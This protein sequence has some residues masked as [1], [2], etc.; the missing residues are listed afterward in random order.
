V[1]RIKTLD[2]LRGLAALS[3]CIFHFTNSNS[4][5]LSDGILKKSGSYGFLGVAVFFVISGY[6]LCNSLLKSKYEIKKFPI[7]ISKRLIRLE[8]PYLLSLVLVIIL[9]YL[10]ERTNI[11]QGQR[12]NFDFVRILSHLGYFTEILGYKWFNPVYWTLAIELQFYILLGIIFPFFYSKTYKFFIVILILL[13]INYLL[14]TD[15]LV[16]HY[17]P[18]FLIGISFCLFSEN[19]LNKYYLLITTSI[20]ILFEIIFGQGALYA[21]VIFFTPFLIFWKPIGDNKIIIFLGKISYSLY[22]IHIPIGMRIINLGA[23]FSHDNFM[24]QLLILL[25]ALFTSIIISFLFYN[26]IEKPSILYAKNFLN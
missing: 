4:N 26:L 21:I 15:K 22:L 1:Q 20:L 7:F 23:R 13:L 19:Y 24:L 10:S 17:L 14:P 12:Q 8:P 11:Y 16:F 18:S 6:V 5:F 25:S 3:V 9:N 2:G